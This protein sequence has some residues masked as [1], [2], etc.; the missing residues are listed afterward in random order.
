ML[1]GHSD[2]VNGL[3]FHRHRPG[4]LATASDDKTALLWDVARGVPVGAVRGRPLH[5]LYLQLDNNYIGAY[6]KCEE[7]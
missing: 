7:G 4:W 1:E 6:L 5:W 3:A 2:E